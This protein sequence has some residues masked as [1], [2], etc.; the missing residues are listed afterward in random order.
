M[1]PKELIE[2]L[3]RIEPLKSVPRHAVTRAGIPECVAA[4]SWRL[5]TIAMLAAEEFPG[6][7]MPRVIRMCLVHDIGEAVTGDIASFQKT[8]ANERTEEHAI[9]GLLSTLPER[10]RG[11]LTALLMSSPFYNIN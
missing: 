9:A 8:A 11:A 1:E 4:H 3:G 6:V 10:E 7:D 2:F 5:A